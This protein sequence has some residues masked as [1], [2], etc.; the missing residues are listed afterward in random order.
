MTKPE[1]PCPEVPLTVRRRTSCVR[2]YLSVLTRTLTSI[3]AVTLTFVV[4][5]ANLPLP[6]HRHDV[7]CLI[8]ISAMTTHS[9]TVG[10]GLSIYIQSMKSYCQALCGSCFVS[11]TLIH[12]LLKYKPPTPKSLK[13]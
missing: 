4:A 10:K 2:D 9:L 7:G 6:L 12:S 13:N 5:P 3:E 1:T 8:Y 11:N